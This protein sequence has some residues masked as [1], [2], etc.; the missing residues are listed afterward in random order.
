MGAAADD[1]IAFPVT[2][3]H[4]FGD[5]LMG[6]DAFTELLHKIML[7]PARPDF[8]G[9]SWVSKLSSA[10]W[11]SR[12]SSED[13]LDSYLPLTKC[14]YHIRFIG[15]APHERSMATY[16]FTDTALLERPSNLEA[17]CFFFIH[18]AFGPALDVKTATAM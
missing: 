2:W 5:F 16:S 3:D 4:T 12:S 9:V 6:R 17:T 1:E 14:L 7:L 18:P 15:C 13:W 8:R 11:E 10:F